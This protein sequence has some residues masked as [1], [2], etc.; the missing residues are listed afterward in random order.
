MVSTIKDYSPPEFLIW[1]SDDT[2]TG[3][4]VWNGEIGGIAHAAPVVVMVEK[5]YDL[6]IVSG[7]D[8]PTALTAIIRGNM[9]RLEEYITKGEFVEPFDVQG[10]VH[11]GYHL[12]IHV[13]SIDPL[14]LTKTYIGGTLEGKQKLLENIKT[15]GVLRDGYVATLR[16]H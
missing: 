11:D 6:S 7:A 8:A 15:E 14:E 10:Y 16:G 1:P 2:V 4:F 5:K 3:F 9:K 13:K 12:K